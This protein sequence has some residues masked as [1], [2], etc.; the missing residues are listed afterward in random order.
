MSLGLCAGSK[1]W[2]LAPMLSVLAWSTPSFAPTPDEAVGPRPL[3]GDETLILQ[4]AQSRPCAAVAL[5]NLRRNPASA[6]AGTFY[7]DQ[8]PTVQIVSFM[9]GHEDRGPLDLP[10]QV[11]PY[12]A[13]PFSVEVRWSI[14]KLS[15]SSTILSAD[16]RLVDAAGVP[17]HPAHPVEL[18]TRVVVGAGTLRV[19]APESSL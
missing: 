13:A 19:L 11:N 5:L 3:S 9:L 17:L 4:I 10:L 7:L 12:N 14:E 8:M 16:A 18:P 15:G 1:R 6:S 2:L